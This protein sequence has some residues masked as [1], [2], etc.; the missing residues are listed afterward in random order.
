MAADRLVLLRIVYEPQ[1][2]L[3][4]AMLHLGSVRWQCEQLG[5]SKNGGAR[6]YRVA[7]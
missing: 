3:M 5:V 7:E 6:A 2:R 1:T 4:D